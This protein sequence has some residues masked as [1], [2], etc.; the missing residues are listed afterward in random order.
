MIKTHDGIN[1]NGLGSLSQWRYAIDIRNVCTYQVLKPIYCFEWGEQILV[2]QTN[3]DL[4]YLWQKVML[5]EEMF[6]EWEFKRNQRIIK[7]AWKLSKIK[8]N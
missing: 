2:F 1:N 3:K 5:E 4:I 7:K 6:G 8:I